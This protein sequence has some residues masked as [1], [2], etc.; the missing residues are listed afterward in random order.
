MTNASM[1]Q[2][3]A[4]GKDGG[5][6]VV[7]GWRRHTPL[8]TSRAATCHRRSRSTIG[9]NG[10]AF[11]TRSGRMGLRSRKRYGMMLAMTITEALRK[12]YMARDE[13]Q[14]EISRATGVAESVLSRFAGGG[15]L[16]SGTMDS[17]CGYLDL[18]LVAKRSK[19]P[20]RRKGR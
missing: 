2:R 10:L 3:S 15:P 18:V 13:T 8:I 12:A 17:L 4:I 9:P 1:T 5:A 20:R 16:R 6:D 7:V 11:I 14:A 19:R